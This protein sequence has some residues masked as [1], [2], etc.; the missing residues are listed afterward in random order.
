MPGIFPGSPPPVPVSAGEW[1]P[2]FH[3]PAQGQP[4]GGQAQPAEL[5]GG[6][7]LTAHAG[8]AQAGMD[9]LTGRV[10]V[11]HKG[12][13]IPVTHPVQ[14]IQQGAVEGIPH[15]KAPGIGGTVDGA[16]HSPV[17]GLPGW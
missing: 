10:W 4:P 8:E 12:V 13:D 7:G 16:L 5:I 2:A 1:V 11:C 15:T 3:C 14:N 17:V 9:T 6:V